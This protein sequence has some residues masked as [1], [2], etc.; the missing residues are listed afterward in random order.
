MLFTISIVL[1]ELVLPEDLSGPNAAAW[2][3][4]N[5]ALVS[6][7]LTL[8]PFAGIAFLWFMGVVRSHLGK[9]EDQFFSSVFVGSGLLFLTMIFV[10]AAIAGGIIAS[11]A[12]AAATGAI[13]SIAA[14][15]RAATP[16]R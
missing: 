4:G 1:L 16:E 2:L 7:A 3:Q 13:N 15:Q 10:A 9:A 6:L 8:A 12:I 5:T 14:K 11:Y